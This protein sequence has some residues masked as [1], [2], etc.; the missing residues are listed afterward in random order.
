MEVKMNHRPLLLT[1]LTLAGCG[2]SGGGSAVPVTVVIHSTN[3]RDGS[4]RSTGTVYTLGMFVGDIDGI[5]PGASSRSMVGFDLL[6]AGIPSGATVQTATL[7]LYEAG[8]AGTPYTDLGNML[9]DHV[10]LGAGLDAADYNGNTLV[11]GFGVFSSDP[12]FAVKSLEVGARVQADLTAGRAFADFRLRFATN[13][14][15]DGSDDYTQFNDSEDFAPFGPKPV[16]TV[17][18][19]P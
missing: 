1:L 15:G 13:S 19:V 7:A 8:G 18:Y 14:N 12:S 11:A 17:T 9:I 5:I 10:A 4:V 3:A 2:G 16:L 6:S